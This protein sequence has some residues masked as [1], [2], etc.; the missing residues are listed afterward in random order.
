M[1]S[2][3][4]SVLKPA[5]EP[6]IVAERKP[7]TS[8][9]GG[10]GPWTFRGIFLSVMTVSMVLASIVGSALAWTSMEATY[11]ENTVGEVDFQVLYT[12][13]GQAVG[14]NNGIM[15]VIGEGAVDNTGIWDIRLQSATIEL[16]DL[17]ADPLCNL[18]MFA[19]EVL[20]V[21]GMAGVIAPDEGPQ[22]TYFVRVAALQH[23]VPQCNG[24]TLS[25]RTSFVFQAAQ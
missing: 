20:T 23:A 7:S 4:V 18:G 9:G 6:A 21:G 15:G 13:N 5:G 2:N 1:S 16:T 8:R 17:A 14:P 22:G 24:A 12:P 3:R 25:Y 10:A 19:A 11:G